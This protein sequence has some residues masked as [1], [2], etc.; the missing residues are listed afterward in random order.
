MVFNEINEKLKYMPAII[1]L[2]YE[3]T[4]ASWK[5]SLSKQLK[6]ERIFFYPS[7]T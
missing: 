5:A 7:C 1:E 2:T 4:D 6:F 3:Y